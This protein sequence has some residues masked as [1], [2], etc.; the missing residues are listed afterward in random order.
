MEV[1]LAPKQSE[2]SWHGLAAATPVLRKFLLTRVRDENEL[3]DVIQETLLRAARYRST[4]ASEERLSGWVVCIALNVLRDRS[5]RAVRH[6]SQ[7]EEPG[8]FDEFVGREQPPGGHSD[9]GVLRVDG[10]VVDREVLLRHLACALRVMTA[11][12]KQVLRAYYSGGESCRV[13]GEVCGVSPALAKVQLFR[14]RRRL[15][16]G[17]RRLVSD[18]KRRALESPLK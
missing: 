18:G 8:S 11:R 12:D 3:D 4:L 1:L 2:Y 7:V 17:L 9:D 14:A 10:A 13:V 16:Q 15:E 5:R 6:K